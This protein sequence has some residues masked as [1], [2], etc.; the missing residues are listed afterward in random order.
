MSNNRLSKVIYIKGTLILLS[1]LLIGGG[2]DQN[3]EI[4][5]LR[6]WEGRPFIP[7]S[8]LA[9]ST[10][11]F[12]QRIV[13][14]NSLID[15]VFGKK[16]DSDTTQSLIIFHD[17]F[18]KNKKPRIQV[19]DGIE[20]DTDTKTAKENAKYDYEVLERGNEFEFRLE[21]LLREIHKDKIQQI[22]EILYHIIQ[23]L[24]D[25]KIRIGAK[26]RRGFGKL[27]LLNP[28]V[29][30]LDMNTSEGI[31]R[32]IEFD[33]DFKGNCDIESLNHK[34]LDI[35]DIRYDSIK[36]KFSIPYSFIIRYY[37]M[38]TDEADMIHLCSD[39]NPVIPGTSWTGAL[40][41]AIYNI[42]KE[43]RKEDKI[44][45]LMKDLF[46][47]VKEE[48]KEKKA[49]RIYIEESIIENAYPVFYIRNKVDR[50]TGGVVEGAL[51]DEKPIYGSENTIVELDIQ[52]Q[53]ASD[54]DIGLI[55]LGL[56]ELWFGIQTVGGEANIGR[57]ILKGK[58]IFINENRIDLENKEDQPYLDA[59]ATY[60]SD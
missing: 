11:D 27:R 41:N 5:L 32:W 20:I 4:D 12:L 56:R 15:T 51:F 53:E 19:R 38:N 52:I 33:W 57:G 48:E 58:E 26:I 21:L 60:L 31:E 6:D 29:L 28:E 39:G 45:L 14:D 43:L 54:K 22:E 55:L 2:E 25:G 10:R 30:I 49:S 59:L 44:D 47:F 23:A 9:G 18:L 17:A 37:S 3:T 36:V 7:G 13:S 50:F 34:L 40:R 24:K 46:G 16:A 35:R 8:S 42:S 1:P